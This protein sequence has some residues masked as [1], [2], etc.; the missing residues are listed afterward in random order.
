MS[1]D[2]LG[3]AEV[4]GLI[5]GAGG[6]C[7]SQV[8]DDQVGVCAGLFLGAFPG[9][10]DT[11]VGLRAAEGLHHGFVGRLLRAELEGIEELRGW[12]ERKAG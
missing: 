5:V 4:V 8:V 11:F 12:G 7:P 2:L 9:G 3:Y 10:V 1:K 6:R